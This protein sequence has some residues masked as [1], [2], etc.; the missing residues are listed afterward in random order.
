M[1]R[2][3]NHTTHLAGFWAVMGPSGSGKS[4]LLNA[5]SLRL[6]P[7][8]KVS[9]EMRLNGREYRNTDLKLSSGYVMQVTKCV[10]PLRAIAL[11]M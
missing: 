5:L 10:L 4:T 9:G 11:Q 1:A 7:G 8:M 6:D 3:V 2:E